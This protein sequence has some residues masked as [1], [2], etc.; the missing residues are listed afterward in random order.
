MEEEK[1]MSSSSS[2]NFNIVGSNTKEIPGTPNGGAT[3]DFEKRSKHLEDENSRLES[4]MQEGFSL[5]E[6]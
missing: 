6:R 1:E 5:Y 4:Q 3:V 2:G